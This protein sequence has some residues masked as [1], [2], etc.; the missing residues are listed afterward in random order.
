MQAVIG[1]PGAVEIETG[2]A[3]IARHEFREDFLAIDERTVLTLAHDGAG[4]AV[5]LRRLDLG[6][7]IDDVVDAVQA[8][9]IAG[10]GIHQR[11]CAEIVAQPLTGDGVGFPATIDLALDRQA[12]E[13]VVVVQEAIRRQEHQVLGIGL[14]CIIKW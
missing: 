9:D 11:Q 8:F 10:L 14:D 1:R 3:D 5:A 4:I 6:Q 2:R 7:F 12:C 13:L